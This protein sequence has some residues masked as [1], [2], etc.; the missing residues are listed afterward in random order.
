MGSAASSSSPA[1]YGARSAP[2]P[3]QGPRLR[4]AVMG[5]R[6]NLPPA[7]NVTFQEKPVP[8]GKF[9]FS[10]LKPHSSKGSTNSKGELS[11]TPQ[12]LRNLSGEN[13]GA[14]ANAIRAPGSGAR[15]PWPP[16]PTR[17]ETS[18]RGRKGPA[19]EPHPFGR[20]RVRAFVSRG[21]QRPPATRFRPLPR[22]PGDPRAGASRRAQPYGSAPPER[23]APR[24]GRARTPGPRP[25]RPT[26]LPRLG[27]GAR[28]CGDA[29]RRHQGPAGWR[30]NRVL[31]YFIYLFFL[32]QSG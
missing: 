29:T 21:G 9:N 14:A 20:A 5:R 25:L 3:A 32:S 17:A 30:G 13:K 19:Q 8:L 10:P 23:P 12:F 18:P 1:A 11:L 2:A 28:R 22:P 27:C 15:P 26:Q 16:P 31:L 7:T 6:A 24:R 4:W